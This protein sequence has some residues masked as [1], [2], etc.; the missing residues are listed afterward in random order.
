MRIAA[1]V[2]VVLALTAHVFAAQTLQRKD[3]PAAVQKTVQA[4]EANGATIKGIAAEKL[5]G[6]TVYEVETTI[7]GHTRD[8]ILDASGAIVEAEEEVSVKG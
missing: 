7:K 3:L 5:G 4:E 2:L 6:K 1:I 8:L